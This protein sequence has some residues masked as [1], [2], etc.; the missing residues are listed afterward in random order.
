MMTS[1][2][3]GESAAKM[4]P[5]V[6]PAHASRENRLPIEIARLQLRRGLVAAI[7]EHH[8]RAHAQA[9]I[10]VYRRHVRTVHAVVLEV[11]VERLHA[12]GAYALR[13]QRADRIIHHR[14]RHARVEA[15]T[16]GQVRGAIEFAAAHVDLAFGRLAERDDPGI[17]AM[18]Q[19][20]QR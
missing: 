12:H 1:A 9:A 15:E 4:P 11:L 3:V 10:A 19:R 2:V 17:Q 7:V 16:I 8:R 13:N 6:E 14:A 20:A 5:R 18:H